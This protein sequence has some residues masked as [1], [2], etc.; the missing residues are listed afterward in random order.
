MVASLW[1]GVGGCVFFEN[2]IVCDKLCLMPNFFGS[3]N[4]FE[5]QFVFLRIFWSG[6]SLWS[7]ELC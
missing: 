1:G 5:C 4:F 2:S 3:Q 6:F 7:E